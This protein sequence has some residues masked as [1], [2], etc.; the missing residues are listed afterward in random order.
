M[1]RRSTGLLDANGREIR[2]GDIIENQAIR[3]RGV[4]RDGNWT[5]ERNMSFQPLQMLLPAVVVG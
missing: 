1:E 4:F 3:D 2:E 5:T